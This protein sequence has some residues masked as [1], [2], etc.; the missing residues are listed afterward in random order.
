MADSEGGGLA[1]IKYSPLSWFVY[2][3]GI[4]A[5]SVP[6]CVRPDSKQ[7]PIHHSLMG[8]QMPSRNFIG[9]NAFWFFNNFS[10]FFC[11]SYLF[12][13]ILFFPILFFRNPHK[14]EADESTSCE[15]NLRC[16]T[17]AGAI[18][19]QV[20]SVTF[21]KLQFVPNARGSSAYSHGSLDEMCNYNA[22]FQLCEIVITGTRN[23]IPIIRTNFQEVISTKLINTDNK[24]KKCT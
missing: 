22:P 16:I 11:Y 18:P 15:Y 3:A 5:I 14:L 20:R 17:A 8:L 1:L 7:I 19:P 23:S 6:Q 4:I 24:T 21:T 10:L 12:F 2:P 13:T 9:D